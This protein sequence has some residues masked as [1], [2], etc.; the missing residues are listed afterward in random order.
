MT[1]ATGQRFIMGQDNGESVA[2]AKVYD[3]NGYFGICS[4]KTGFDNRP[5][6]RIY[7]EAAAHFKFTGL[8]NSTPAR[9]ECGTLTLSNLPTVAP[10]NSGEVWNDGGTLKVS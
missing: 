6:A 2:M 5:D 7:R 4:A 3:P 10:A 9:V 1:N 8:L